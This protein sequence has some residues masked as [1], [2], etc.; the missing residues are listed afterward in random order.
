MVEHAHPPTFG[1]RSSLAPSR[2]AQARLKLISQRAV[3]PGQSSRRP[4]FLF[5]EAMH[6]RTMPR[7]ASE[8]YSAPHPRQ[9]KNPKSLLI[10]LKLIRGKVS[11]KDFVKL[12]LSKGRRFD[13]GI[14]SARTLGMIERDEEYVTYV[15]LEQY[16]DYTGIPTG[17]LLLFSRMLANKRNRDSGEEGEDN[18]QLA[19]K[20][21]MMMRRVSSETTFDTKELNAWAEIFREAPL[22]HQHVS[23]RP[24]TARPDRAE[25]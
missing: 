9:G 13:R 4:G 7:K 12:L 14:D 22:L 18:L 11:Q 23:S 19:E 17:M 16:R 6:E 2:C 8:L 15:H 25:H 10:L 5:L 21:T 3:W 1:R 24:E 20:V